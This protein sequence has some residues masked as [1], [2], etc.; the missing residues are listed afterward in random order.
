MIKNYVFD[1]GSVLHRHIPEA[2][3][4]AA[5]GENAERIMAVVFDRL[6]WDRLDLGTIEEEEMKK[7]FYARLP[8]DQ[9]QLACA[10]LDGWLYNLQPVEGMRDLIVDIKAGGAKVFLLSNINKRFA[11]NWSM[12][13]YFKELFSHFD[14]LVCS[15]EVG[16]VKPGREIFDYLLKTYGLK[17]EECLFT[18]DTL[19]NIEAAKS[20]GFQTYH[21][22]GDAQKLR[23]C[24][25]L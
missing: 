2:K 8:R 3:I 7:D 11:A 24:L 19:A 12:N 5:M 21:F 1:C 17:A 22:D 6:Y 16:F 18:D 15:A 13:P 4:A 10:V 14:G 23:A 20:Y 9:A 25:D